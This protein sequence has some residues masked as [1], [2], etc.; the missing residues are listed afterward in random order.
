M[1]LEKFHKGLLKSN[2]TVK[3]AL[4][5]ERGNVCEECHITNLWNGYPLVLQVD[6]IDGDNKNNFPSNVR[7]ICPNCH[8]QTSNYCALNISFKKA[9]KK[10]S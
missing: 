8:S 3:K 9:L 7:L 5:E 4:I 1:R 10:F 6:H 2:P